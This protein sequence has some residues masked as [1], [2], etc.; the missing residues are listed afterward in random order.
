[1]PLA[2]GGATVNSKQGRIEIKLHVEKLTAANQFGSEY[3]TYVLWAI[4]PEGRP[5]NLG[6]VILG[7]VPAATWRSLPTC[8]PS[9]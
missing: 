3:L 6:E 9:A 8:K 2:R 5:K 4:T 7:A 1:M